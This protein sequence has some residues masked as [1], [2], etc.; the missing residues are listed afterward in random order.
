MGIFSP[1][2]FIFSDY[3]NTQSDITKVDEGKTIEENCN[4][5]PETQILEETNTPLLSKDKCWWLNSGGIFYRKNSVS[6]TIISDLP[7]D[8]VW[9]TR[10]AISS[11]SDTDGGL[12]PQN[13]FRLVNKIEVKDSEQELI[14]EIKNYNT[15]LSK[16]RN[17]SNGV[18]LM[19]KYLDGNNLYYAGVRVDGTAVIKKKING[20]YVTLTEVKIEPGEY[21]QEYNPNLLPINKI[22]AEKVTSQNNNDGSVNIDFYVDFNV[23]PSLIPNWQKVISIKDDKSPINGAGRVG[24]RTDFMDVEFENYSLKIL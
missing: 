11:N 21:N 3:Q 1:N 15:S 9:R 24:I 19:T 2:Q 20:Q 16:N 6:Q 18:F 12:H 4:I 23:G 13:L 8:S 7:G 14:F 22:L 17:A 5:L 10:Y